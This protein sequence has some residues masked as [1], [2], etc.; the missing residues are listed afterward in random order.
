M[1]NLEKMEKGIE[2]TYNAYYNAYDSTTQNKSLLREHSEYYS[3]CAL[4]KLLSLPD[5]MSVDYTRNGNIR[6]DMAS[7]GAIG[8]KNELLKNV[9]N[10]ACLNKEQDTKSSNQ[11]GCQFDFEN[12]TTD[13]MS[14]VMLNNIC[15]YGIDRGYALLSDPNILMASSRLFTHYRLSSDKVELDRIA[16][17]NN[18]AQYLDGESDTYYAQRNEGINF[19]N[20]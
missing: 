10:V 1:T 19:G 9:I 17:T 15:Q 6:Y 8:I 18:I 16:N 2:Y 14:V 12:M 3:A 20:K 5:C 11:L 7:V 4:S 13:D